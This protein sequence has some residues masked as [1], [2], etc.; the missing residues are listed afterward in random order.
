LNGDK[1][2]TWTHTSPNG[3]T[4]LWLK[5]LLP[6]KMPN[7]NVMTFGYNASVFGNTS[8]AG[9]RENSRML[10]GLLRDKREDYVG[11]SVAL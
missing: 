2:G 1:F 9:V 10:L 4:T 7:V 5:D 6:H 11:L 3:D 8:V